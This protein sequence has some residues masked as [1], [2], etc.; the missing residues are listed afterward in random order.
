MASLATR[1]S[2]VLWKCTRRERLFWSAL[3][4]SR[5]GNPQKLLLWALQ[6][7]HGFA[8][9]PP[10]ARTPLGKPYFPQYH[11]LHFNLSHSGPLTVCALSTLPVGV[12]I[13]QI[14]PR[15]ASLPRYA[16]TEREYTVFQRMGGD[17]PAFYA[18]WTRR[19][20]WCKYTGQ[21]L[22][23]QWKQDIPAT[24]LSF[25]AYCGEGW[26]A[27]VCGLEPPPEAILWKEDGAL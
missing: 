19:E 26:Q 24:G 15:G 11:G 6:Q 16:L 18:L 8:A 22:K 23:P 9:L 21:G 27:S 14:R 17:W 4:G 5:E 10:L 13:E 7:T 25:G 20:A 2:P 12:D 1:C 3:Y